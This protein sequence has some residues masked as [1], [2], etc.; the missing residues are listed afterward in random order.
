MGVLARAGWRNRRGQLRIFRSFD[1]AIDL[2][3]PYAPGA[4]R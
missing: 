4:I 2:A 1:R 3:R